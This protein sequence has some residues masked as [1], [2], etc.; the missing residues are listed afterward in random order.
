MRG[1]IL[2]N[3]IS[4]RNYV[5]RTFGDND[6]EKKAQLRDKLLEKIP[7]ISELRQKCREKFLA[8]EVKFYLQKEKDVDNLLKILCDTFPDYVDRRQTEKGLGLVKNDEDY[9]IYQIDCLKKMVM[10]QEDEGLDLKIFEW[11][12]D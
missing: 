4:I 1:K 10:S 12:R 11:I 6:T 8:I 7:N 3:T 9:M 2:L 5:P